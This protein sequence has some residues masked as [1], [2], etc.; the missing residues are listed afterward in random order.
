MNRVYINDRLM[1]KDDN[2]IL[3][4]IPTI[5]IGITTGSIIEQQPEGTTEVSNT[6]SIAGD[7]G[8]PITSR[9]IC[10]GT[11]NP[12]TLADNYTT[13]GTGTGSFNSSISFSFDLATNYYV[14]AY[15]TNAVGTEYGNTVVFYVQLTLYEDYGLGVPYGGGTVYY[16]NG[17]NSYILQ[18][19][20][21]STSTQ[22]GAATYANNLTYGPFSDYSLPSHVEYQQMGLINIYYWSSTSCETG[23]HYLSNNG[24]TVCENDTEYHGFVCI[25]KYTI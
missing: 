5:P 7:G 18:I 6:N 17:R 12:P 3:M 2:L 8:N 23:K 16:I 13:N 1:F 15:A 22:S 9:G 4:E 21:P 10:W 24:P 19:P 20:V 14:R 25:R 11:N